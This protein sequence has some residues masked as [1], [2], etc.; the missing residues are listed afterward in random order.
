MRLK[1]LFAFLILFT[2]VLFSNE[3]EAPPGPSSAGLRSYIKA[4][5][6]LDRGIQAIGG[7]DQLRGIRT[8][9]RKLSGDWLSVGQGKRPFL[10]PSTE[11]PPAIMRD[12][13]TSFL[14][15]AGKRWYESVEYSDSLGDSAIQSDV[16]M[17]NEG[18]TMQKYFEEKPL[19]RKFAVEDLP[20]MRTE[21][22]RRFPEGSLLMALERSETLS[23]I[24]FSIESDRPQDVISFTDPNGAHVLLSFDAKTHL[25]TKSETLRA[26]SVY[27]DTYAEVIYSDYRD[28]GKLKLPFG[29]VD[30]LAGIPTER[31]LASEIQV[32]GN[33]PEDHFRPPDAFVTVQENPSKPAIEK[34]GEDLFVI[35]G[36][37]NVVF[38][39]FRDFVLVF[40]APESSRYSEECL[41]LIRSTAPG[42]PIRQVI[43][44]HFHFDHIAGVRTYIAEGIPILTTSHPKRII[45]QALS[46]RHTM[47]PDKLSQNPKSPV[48]ETFSGEKIFDDGQHRVEIYDIGPTVHA[49]QILVAYFPKERLLFQADLLDISSPDLVL[50]YSATK[51]LATKIQE[52]GLSVQRIIPAHGIPGTIDSLNQAL[53]VREKYIHSRAKNTGNKW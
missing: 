9:H 3:K 32:N 25:L 29:Y 22:F 26:H 8:V 4:R 24:G 19:Y 43:L 53:A 21:K 48:I 14:D 47:R 44:T 36:S 28:V 5:A 18:F 50:A 34:L 40:E 6:I 31:L 17:E 52:L 35:R 38:A 23:W 1:L 41:R 10:T 27:G 15:Y 46:S 20:S 42:K 33:F 39:V 45:E 30:R 37:Y 12:N 2:Q 49:D 11:I 51:I 16:V 13:I 7:L